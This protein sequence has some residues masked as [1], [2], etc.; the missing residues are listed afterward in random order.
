MKKI[1]L[2]F[3]LVILLSGCTHDYYTPNAQNV[4]MFRDKNELRL[5]GA[6]GGSQSEGVELQAAYS[7]VK[8][9][10][11]MANYLTSSIHYNS[12]GD[13][14]NQNYIEGGLGYYKPISKT[15]VFEIYGGYG[16]GNEH[17]QY[18]GS[19]Y[20]YDGTYYYGSGFA[21]LSFKKVFIQP[22]I[23]LTFDFID[24]AFSSRLYSLTFD[25]VQNYASVDSF[26][27]GTLHELSLSNVHYFL[28]PAM[29]FRGG[30]KNVKLQLQL[31]TT[32]LLSL[33]DP[34]FSYET[35]HASLGV[36]FT[37]NVNKKIPNNL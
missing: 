33:Q 3:A 8:N 14:G 12:P 36:C 34:I 24:I 13:Y 22:S 2:P 6:F 23:G 28:E 19:Y 11:V 15:A 5:S 29:T 32:R 20:S 25:K 17:H 16:S 26:D 4:P 27:W 7:P 30:W 9:F 37:L 31:S 1:T 21:N 10:A 18:E 35:L